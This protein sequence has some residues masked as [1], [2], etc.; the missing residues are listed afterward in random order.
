[1]VKKTQYKHL[2]SLPD[3][4]SL[5]TTSPMFGS[6]IRRG[7]CSIAIGGFY[8]NPNMHLHSADWNPRRLLLIKSFLKSLLVNFFRKLITLFQKKEVLYTLSPV[9]RCFLFSPSTTTWNTVLVIR[10]HRGTMCFSSLIFP[11]T[12]ALRLIDMS[13]A[14]S[15]VM[16]QHCP[17][18]HV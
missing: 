15:Q 10:G 7:D 16:S 1:M 14:Q 2:F 6:C 5:G 17:L 3:Y 4:S 9:F 12:K 11:F 18:F 13:S 8:I